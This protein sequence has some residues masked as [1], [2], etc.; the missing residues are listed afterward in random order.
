MLGGINSPTHATR[1]GIELHLRELRSQNSREP[2][3]EGGGQ[4]GERWC[5][6]EVFPYDPVPIQHLNLTGVARG[7]DQKNLM[8]EFKRQPTPE[9]PIP[10]KGVSTDTTKCSGPSEENIGT[11]L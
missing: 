4:G 10:Y 6:P 11:I 2:I 5:R 1:R 3:G 7:K 9:S 8:R